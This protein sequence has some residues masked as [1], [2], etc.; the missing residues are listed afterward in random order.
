MHTCDSL[1]TGL[2]AVEVM[3]KQENSIL[4][5]NYGI[6][7]AQKQE[8]SKELDKFV[9][10]EKKQRGRKIFWRGTAICTTLISV[11]LGILVFL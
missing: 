2:R 5:Q 1:V 3:L 9:K 10:E 7:Q 4:T 6:V 8:L 11:L